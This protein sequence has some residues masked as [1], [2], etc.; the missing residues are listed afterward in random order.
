M[1]YI[2]TTYFPDHW[3]NVS[4]NSISYKLQFLKINQSQLVDK[5]PTIFLRLNKGIKTIEKAWIGKVFDINNF[6][7]NLNFSILVRN[8]LTINPD[9]SGIKIGW[10]VI[11]ED[12]IINQ[13]NTY[14]LSN[15]AINKITGRDFRMDTSIVDKILQSGQDEDE[16]DD[17][18]I[19]KI[20]KKVKNW[21]VR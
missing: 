16:D 3:D 15:N 21:F 7:G 11:D 14:T 13:D 20:F 6:N 10:F 18:F 12:L 5:T 19:I 4:G 9:C 1:Y 8:S 17:N 2:L